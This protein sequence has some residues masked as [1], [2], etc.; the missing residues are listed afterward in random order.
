MKIKEK[1]NVI[2]LLL[3]ILLPF[4]C[5]VW[6]AF[7]FNNSLQTAEQSSVQSTTVVDTVQK[8]VK[9]IAPQSKIAN[10]TGSAYDK[11]HAVIRSLAHFAEFALLGVLLGWCYFAYTM[12]WKYFFIPSIFVLIIPVIDEW[13]QSFVD[14]RAWEAFDL[15]LDIFGGAAGITFAALS[16]FVGLLVYE[17]ETKRKAKKN[18]KTA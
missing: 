5:L 9:V 14:G 3:K 16:V 7:I 17:K 1:Q 15:V 10:A 4:A 12:K 13:I 2:N 18:Q 11:L 8:V 6:I